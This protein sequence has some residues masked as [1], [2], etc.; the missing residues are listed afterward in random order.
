MKKLQVAA[1]VVLFFVLVAVGISAALSMRY[2]LISTAD[3]DGV[4]YLLDT[5]TGRMKFGNA[6][7]LEVRE[8][9]WP[10]E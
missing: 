8:K 1:A 5:W 4:V 3:P 7:I 2:K 9:E 6:Y 10:R